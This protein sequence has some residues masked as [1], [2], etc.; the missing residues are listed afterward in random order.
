[1]NST[2]GESAKNMAVSALQPASLRPGGEVW[3]SLYAVFHSV[4][5]RRV[6]GDSTDK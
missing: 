6:R 4:V 1:M 5:L 3:R 2:I